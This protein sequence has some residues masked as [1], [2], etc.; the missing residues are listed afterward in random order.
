MENIFESPENSLGQSILAAKRLYKGR[1]MVEMY[2][3]LGDPALRLALPTLKMTS[4]VVENNLEMNI[5]TE[6]FDGNAV[7]ETLDE[8]NQV[9]SKREVVLNTTTDKIVL[10]KAELACSQGRIYVW[11]SKQNIDAMTSFECKTTE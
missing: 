5:E 8:S 6:H 1:T 4:Q 3:L 2:N 9:I 10:S 11:D 7:L